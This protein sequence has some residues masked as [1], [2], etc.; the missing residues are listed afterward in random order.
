MKRCMKQIAVCV[1]LCLATFSPALAQ[2]GSQGDISCSQKTGGWLTLNQVPSG[3][4]PVTAAS[5]LMWVLS[6]NCGDDVKFAITIP[7]KHGVLRE[8]KSEKN[9]V[10]YQYDP[11]DGHLSR[12]SFQITPSANGLRL[13]PVDISVN[14]RRSAKQL[15]FAAGM[16]AMLA[17][18]LFVRPEH[19]CPCDAANVNSFDRFA[20][21]QH[22]AA[23]ARTSDAL[24]YGA[25][26]GMVLLFGRG[27]SWAADLGAIGETVLANEAVTSTIK[28]YVA[29]PRPL[30]YQPNTALDRDGT[31][32]SFF[33]G[34]TSTAFAVSTAFAN[35]YIKRHELTGKKALL[36]RTGVWALAGT[37]GSLRV[38]AGKHYPTDVLT[39]AAVG[40]SLGTF[41]P[42]LSR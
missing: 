31:Y 13:Q 15:V 2:G 14:G 23:A 29:R 7:P 35:T 18:S 8:T 36:L 30:A 38:A 40:I 6:A 39:G 11:A 19:S 5:N 28:K 33:S 3:S 4:P 17:G 1:F 26:P 10:T 20:T 25:L 32:T 34:H 37:V 42:K 22:S 24:L 16:G 12:D 9:Q 27:E 21:R 41:V